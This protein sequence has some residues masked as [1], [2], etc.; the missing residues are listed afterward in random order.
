MSS[1]Q[2]R[3]PTILVVDDEPGQRQLLCDFV[4]SLGMRALE[5]SS[6]EEGLETLRQQDVDML[7]LDV[8]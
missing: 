5:A 3:Q 2:E 6:A 1:R 8:R 4:T 7:L